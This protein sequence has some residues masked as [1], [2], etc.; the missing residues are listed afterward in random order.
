M[1]RLLLLIIGLPLLLIA[2]GGLLA[3]LLVDQQRLVSLAATQL[4]QRTGAVLEVHGDSSLRLFPELALALGDAELTLPGESPTRV[5]AET[6]SLAAKLLPLLQ[7]RAEIDSLSIRQARVF[8]PP[9]PGKTAGEPLLINSFQARDI[10]LAGEPTPISLDLTV[11]GDEPLTLT[12]E[13]RLLTAAGL[14]NLQL[15]D[16]QAIVREASGEPRVTLENGSGEF[17]LADMRA[18][19]R[20]ERLQIQQHPLT[21]V[22]LQLRLR[23]GGDLRIDSLTGDL[24]QGQLATQ[25][26]IWIGETANRYALEG[27]LSGLSLEALLQAM[28]LEAGLQGKGDLQWQLRA[29]GAETDE[30]LQSLSGTVELDSDALTLRDIGVEGMLCQVV[31]QVNQEA[32]STAFPADTELR[33]LHATLHFAD[34]QMRLDPLRGSLEHIELRGD[35]RL[36]LLSGDLRAELRARLS[37]GLGETDRA[38]R[39][40]P[41]LAAIDWPVKCRGQL[42][43]SPKDWCR[44]DAES[45]LADL[46]RNELEGKARKEAGRLLQRLLGGDR[47]EAPA[48]PE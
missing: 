16:L 7:G 31:A 19:L 46:A 10:N 27:K 40:N 5:R 39:I 30:L 14:E 1:R 18:T 29:E 36:A 42:G 12:L 11:P 44:V 20:A 24:H 35:G 38:C 48:T 26:S 2:L 28:E 47:E 43:T 21:T 33:P 45:I 25:G 32:L 34:G 3:W 9:Q 8:L 4:E 22:I 17:Q 41:R 13:G 6:L 23:A 15:Q 37:E